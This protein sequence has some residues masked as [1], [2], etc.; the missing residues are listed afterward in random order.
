[1]RKKPVSID[2]RVRQRVLGQLRV[3]NEQRFP[4]RSVKGSQNEFG[5]DEQDDGY[6]DRDQREKRLAPD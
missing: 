6:R 5:A 4:W 3:F 2:S 1:V